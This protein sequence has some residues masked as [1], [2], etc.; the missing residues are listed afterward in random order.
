MFTKNMGKRYS[1]H[2]L[3]YNVIPQVDVLMLKFEIL[4]WQCRHIIIIYH[5]YF[6]LHM[7]FT[8][9]ALY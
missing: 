2:C 5:I 3:R 1:E 9:T 4:S 6:V 8:I 7:I